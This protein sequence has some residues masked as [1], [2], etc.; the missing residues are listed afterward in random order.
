MTARNGATGHQSVRGDASAQVG[1]TFRLLRQFGLSLAT[2][3]VFM[4]FAERV[5]WS[6][7][8]AGVDDAGSL[9]ATWL[10]YSV[11]A[12]ICLVAIRTFRVRSVWAMFLVGA[13][14]GWLV[15][16]VF[17]MTFFGADGIPFPYTIAWTGL[18]WHALIVVV[19]GW[20]GL[21]LALLRSLAST[22]LLSTALGVFWG[23]WSIFWDIEAP[24][25]T[26]AAFVIHGFAA[27]ALLIVA[28]KVFHVLRSRDFDMWWIG[29]GSLAAVVLLYF[30]CVTV[31][32]FTWLALICLPPLFALIYLGL[33][34]N[35]VIETRPDFLVA[36][37]QRVPWG[38]SLALLMMPFV[39]S[40]I[41]EGCR[42]AGLSAS[43]NLFVFALTLP[44]GFLGFLVSLW[45]VFRQT[46]DASFAVR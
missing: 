43:T 45:M 32:R 16:G 34:Y 38:R 9:L 22:L 4:F 24:S 15:E 13:L 33:R 30:C 20:Y 39:A 7:W 28:F 10:L 35:A 37:D 5:F 3:Y 12:A 6:R 42:V 41:H 31:V 36:A 26:M 27:T 46:P 29:R 40:L 8:R 2:G 19:I 1:R 21:Q 44:A 23:V 11:A 18:S 17:T 14:L 25:N